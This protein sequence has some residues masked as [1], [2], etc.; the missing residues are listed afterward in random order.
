MKY[1]VVQINN[2]KLLKTVSLFYQNFK[3]VTNFRFTSK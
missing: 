2:Q 3:V 1:S